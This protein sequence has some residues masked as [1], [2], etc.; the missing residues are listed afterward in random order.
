MTL[1]G[2]TRSSRFLNKYTANCCLR[3]RS[4]V[5]FSASA[6]KVWVDKSNGNRPVGT[7]V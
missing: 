6:M 7:E 4:A 1:L 2:S 3:G 5:R